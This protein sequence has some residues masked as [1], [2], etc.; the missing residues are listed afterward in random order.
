MADLTLQEYLRVATQYEAAAAL[1]VTQGA[2]SQMAASDREI[3][4]VT[5][6]DGKIIRTYEVKTMG[7][8]KST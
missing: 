3:R 2:V 1:G 8:K 7:R 5:D 4:I 6:M